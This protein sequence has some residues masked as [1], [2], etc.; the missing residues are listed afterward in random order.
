MIFGLLALYKE[1]PVIV[2]TTA[3]LGAFAFF[4]GV[5]YYQGCNFFAVAELLEHNIERPLDNSEQIELDECDR[6]LAFGWLFMASLGV[7]LQYKFFG[8]CGDSSQEQLSAMKQDGRPGAA[9]RHGPRELLIVR[10]VRGRN[11]RRHR[12]KYRNNKSEVEERREEAQRLRDKLI[13]GSS[14]STAE[15]SRR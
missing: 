6:V 9:F 3:L 13:E 7:L 8:R 1:K 5:G 14:S 2:G 15:N 4:V 10:E 11:S 12:D